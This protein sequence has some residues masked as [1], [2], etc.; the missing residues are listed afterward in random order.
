VGDY[1]KMVKTTISNN[2]SSTYIQYI[3]RCDRRASKI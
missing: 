1:I 2:G 3:R